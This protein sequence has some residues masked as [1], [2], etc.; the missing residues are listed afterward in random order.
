MVGSPVS[1]RRAVCARRPSSSGLSFGA[2]FVSVAL[3]SCKLAAGLVCGGR[4]Y[5]RGVL[6]SP[7]VGDSVLGFL[8]VFFVVFL[9]GGHSPV[10][11]WWS[12][13]PAVSVIAGASPAGNLI[14]GDRKV[15][16]GASAGFF[17]RF[18]PLFPLFLRFSVQGSLP[19]LSPMRGGRKR[20]VVVESKSFD[21]ELVGREEDLLRISEN[22]RGRRFSLTLP[23]LASH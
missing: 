15:A 14:A 19:W 1:R 7:V 5:L 3:G 20:F 4:R 17:R 9:V 21:F 2:C 13:R 10:L 18:F 6:R 11:G 8:R 16:G 12:S 23:A 22:G